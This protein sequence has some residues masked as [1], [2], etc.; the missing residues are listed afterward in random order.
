MSFD[1]LVTMYDKEANER[2][3]NYMQ[4]I[5][6]FG[7]KSRRKYLID[8]NQYSEFNDM[9]LEEL[10]NEAEEDEDAGIRMRKRRITQ[11]LFEFQ[12]H[13]EK[14]P[15]TH[16]Q[17][18]KTVFLSPSTINNIIASV[19]LFY[20]TYDI[21][22]PLI[23]YRRTKKENLRDV[24]TK[25][26][27]RTAIE[28]SPSKLHKAVITI[29]ASSGLDTDT[30]LRITVGDYITACK[31][32]SYY[33]RLPDILADL[34]KKHEIIPTFIMD[35]GKT[36]YEHIFFFSPEACDYLNVYLLDRMKRYGLSE[37]EPLIP[38]GKSGVHAF[39]NRLN[40]EHNFG[41]TSNG[42]RRRFR[43]HAMRSFFA[44]SLQGTI[45]N[46]GVMIDS[47]IIEFM[48]GHTIPTTTAA[49]YKKKPEVL[50]NVY[51]RMV[52]KLTFMSITKVK[53]ISSPEYKELQKQLE[54]YKELEKKVE[55]LEKLEDLYKKL[56]KLSIE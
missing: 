34:S 13:L 26:E 40:D 41:W 1:K 17:T 11:R 50:K 9:S 20:M 6:G 18:K 15:R 22:L 44:T 16:P 32:Y 43:P 2:V 7:D 27:I 49:Y 21:Q 8:L 52:P 47:M 37:D 54:E 55:K 14:N 53:T 5:R 33:S 51:V 29:L 28:N 35:R 30:L 46:E 12:E 10:L 3:L 38:L 31:S 48:L 23:K 42:T 25:K 39:F 19:K 4:G 56:E 45:I 36:R 24:L